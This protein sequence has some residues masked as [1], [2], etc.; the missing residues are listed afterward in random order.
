MSVHELEINK[1]DQEV[2][3]LLQ[4]LLDEAEAG[5]L[6]SIAIVTSY[7]NYLTGNGWAGMDK[8]STAILGELAALQHDIINSGFVS[9]RRQPICYDE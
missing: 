9:L 6:Q 3:E 1:P 2:I 5:R 4:A 7:G 8:N